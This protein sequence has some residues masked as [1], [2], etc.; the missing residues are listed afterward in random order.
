[1]AVFYT[2]VFTPEEASR[3]MAYENNKDLA[4]NENSQ[5]E[6]YSKMVDDVKTY[7]IMNEK[8]EEV[9]NIW[10]KCKGDLLGW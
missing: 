9:Y 3:W 6:L 4:V 10:E 2:I 1:M 8:G 7:Y 5:Y